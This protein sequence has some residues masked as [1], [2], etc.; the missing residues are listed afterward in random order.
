VVEDSEPVV[1][2]EPVVVAVVVVLEHWVADEE[3]AAGSQHPV[4]DRGDVED[5]DYMDVD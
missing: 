5:R 2:V 1:V 3:R 4:V